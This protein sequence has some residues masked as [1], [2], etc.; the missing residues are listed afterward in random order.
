MWSFKDELLKS[1]CCLSPSSVNDLGL[2]Q[3]QSVFV[4]VVRYSTLLKAMERNVNY[5]KQ[6]AEVTDGI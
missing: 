3:E 2:S 1:S 5:H 4:C 6:A